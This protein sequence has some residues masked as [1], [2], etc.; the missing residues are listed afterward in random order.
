[1]VTLLSCIGLLLEYEGQSLEFE[2]I[3]DSFDVAMFL[4]CLVIVIV[5]V[6]I[7]LKYEEGI[8]HTTKLDIALTGLCL[9]GLVY[10]AIIADSF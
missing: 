5:S 6:V 2:F 7:E 4:C 10:E 8:T 3:L 9:L 1:M